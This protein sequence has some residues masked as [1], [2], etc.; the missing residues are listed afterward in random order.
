MHI[1]TLF[2]HYQLLRFLSRFSS[3]PTTSAGRTSLG[4][5]DYEMPLIENVPA[6]YNSPCM[7]YPLYNILLNKYSFWGNE[8][9][10]CWA[11]RSEPVSA[12]MYTKLSHHQLSV[13]YC[14]LPCNLENPCVT[15][16]SN[17]MELFD[18]K[19]SRR[20]KNVYV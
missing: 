1:L 3:W 2:T 10:G 11:V 19:R 8:F 18:Q 4:G 5:Y 16:I 17:Y 13:L 12:H 14:T 20:A 7:C 6:V 15:Q 9:G